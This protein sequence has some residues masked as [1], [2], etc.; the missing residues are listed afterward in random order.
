MQRTFELPFT[1]I[2]SRSHKLQLPK[3]IIEYRFPT[4]KYIVNPILGFHEGGIRL[5]KVPHKEKM[6]EEKLLS[7]VALRGGLVLC[8][9]FLFYLVIVFGCSADMEAY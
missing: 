6:Q 5:K 9:F 2:D 3:H 1:K 8:V 4:N 7:S